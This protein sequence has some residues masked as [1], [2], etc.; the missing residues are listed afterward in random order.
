MRNRNCFALFFF[1]FF[2]ADGIFFFFEV[3]TSSERSTRD[4]KGGFG[5]TSFSL[6][7]VGGSQLPSSQPRTQTAAGAH[8]GVTLLP[9]PGVPVLH[10]LIVTHK[11]HVVPLVVL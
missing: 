3:V 6:F 11:V 1:F 7:L 4:Q 5:G 2:F 9:A 10:F 8:G